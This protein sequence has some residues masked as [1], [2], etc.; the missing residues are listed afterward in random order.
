[1]PLSVEVHDQMFH[2][3]CSFCD[4]PGGQALQAAEME[5][6]AKE[7]LAN[8]IKEINASAKLDQGL[9]ATFRLDE[10]DISRNAP[11]SAREL[12]AVRAYNN[13]VKIGPKNWLYLYGGYGL[14]KTHLAIAALRKLALVNEWTARVAVWPELCQLT[15]ESWSANFGPTEAQLWNRVR[16]ARLLLIDD[17]DKTS[18]N[19]WAMGKLYSLINN[20]L[21]NELPTIITSN[22]SF[23]QLQSVWRKSEKEHVH[24]L[25][26][27]V[28]S[29]I[30]EAVWGTIH[31][32]GEDQRW[33]R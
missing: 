13:S 12:K 28:L 15:K 22:H 9:Y 31:F 6:L 19:E 33:I 11:H 26:L 10:W 16:S 1:M 14:G 30:A 18:T 21:T 25:G 3:L 4:C 29:R 2:H 17:L 20:R 5:A 24:D 27:A 32:Q 23:T 7:D 8:R